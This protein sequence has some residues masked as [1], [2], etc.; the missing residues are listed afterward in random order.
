[1]KNVS[2]CWRKPLEKIHTDKPYIGLKCVE[3][4]K[5]WETQRGTLKEIIWKAFPSLATSVERLSG[6]EIRWQSTFVETT[7]T[8]KIIYKF[9]LHILGPKVL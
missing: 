9:I 7:R 4:R 8:A 3:K 2:L 1:M 6:Q 5:S